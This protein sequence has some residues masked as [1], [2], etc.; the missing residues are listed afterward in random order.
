M[1]TNPCDVRIHDHAWRRALARL[2]ILIDG[3]H[4]GADEIR[5]A[6]ADVRRCQGRLVV[7]QWSGDDLS[8]APGP[9]FEHMLRR[10]ETRSRHEQG[11]GGATGVPASP[12]VPGVA[13][14]SAPSSYL[15]ENGFS[16]QGGGS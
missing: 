4:V 10:F 2:S 1:P 14:R 8:L 15:R 11:G 7:V 9:A 5:G 6:L 3:G 12:H 13:P 16:E